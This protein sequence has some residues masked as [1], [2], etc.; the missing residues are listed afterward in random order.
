MTLRED[1]QRATTGNRPAV[2]A[3]L[4]NTTIGYHRSTNKPNI[5]RAIRRAARH[6]SDLIRAMTSTGTT[7]Q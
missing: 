1:E 3:V 5:A 7:T 6:T 2:F 4:R